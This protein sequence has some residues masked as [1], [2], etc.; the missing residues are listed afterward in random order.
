M[1]EDLFEEDEII[2]LTDEEGKEERFIV[3]CVIEYKGKQ[4]YALLPEKPA[5]GE[6]DGY[7]ILRED[8]EEGESMLVTIDDDNEF[9]EVADEIDEYL[10]SEIDFDENG[11]E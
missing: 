8:E 3:L 11:D 5:D 9:D 2:T 6:D 10:N 4:Y 1:A 7:V